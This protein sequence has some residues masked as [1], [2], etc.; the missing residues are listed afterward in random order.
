MPYIVKSIRESLEQGR[1]PTKPGELNYLMS[2]LVKGFLAING[3]SYTSFNAVV[4]VLECLKL[5][6]Y[7]RKIANYEQDKCNENGDV[8]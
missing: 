4:G 1:V 7:R 5:E 2:Q 6:L 8:F 3:E